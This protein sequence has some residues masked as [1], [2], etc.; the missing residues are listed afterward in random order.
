MMACFTYNDISMLLNFYFCQLVCYLLDPV[1]QSFGVKSKEK[2]SRLVGVDEN[3]GVKMCYKLVDDESGKIICRSIIRSA[4]EPGTANLRIDP[5]KPLPPDT[6]FII[7]P[8]AMLDEMMTRADFE[9]LLL[10]VDM[11][12]PIDLIP[13]STKSKTWQEMK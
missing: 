1:D 3:I 11:V 13:T 4:I 6:I 8:D 2:R 5:I 7:E 10:K 12:D 9:T